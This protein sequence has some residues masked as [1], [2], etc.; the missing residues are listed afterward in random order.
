[1]QFE[2]VTTLMIHD[3]TLQELAKEQRKNR[4]W[5]KEW[6][7]MKK[8]LE[9]EKVVRQELEDRLPAYVHR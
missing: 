2:A 6:G 8:A 9:N 5:E 4:R 7:E 1:M 3:C